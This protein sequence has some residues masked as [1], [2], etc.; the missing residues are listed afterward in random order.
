MS[1]APEKC[2]YRVS[3]AMMLKEVKF[4]AEVEAEADMVAS[5]D[6]VSA[7]EAEQTCLSPM[8]KLRL[9]CLPVVKVGERMAVYALVVAD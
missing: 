6:Q 5:M 9:D 2:W 7:R 8:L 4:L 3:A 1:K